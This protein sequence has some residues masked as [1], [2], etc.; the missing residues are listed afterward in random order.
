[1]IPRRAR[2][3]AQTQDRLPTEGD[4]CAPAADC[5][6]SIISLIWELSVALA[7][8]CQWIAGRISILA[9]YQGCALTAWS[10]PLETLKCSFIVPIYP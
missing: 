1:M 8:L 5:D 2:V 6:A 3:E 4:A 10:R 9:S 7:T